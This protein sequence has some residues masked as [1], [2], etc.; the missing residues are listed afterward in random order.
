MW[1]ASQIAETRKTIAH[2][3]VKQILMSA[4]GKEL[5]SGQSARWSAKSGHWI[6]VTAISDCSV[7]SSS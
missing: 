6:V 4:M 3:V 5:T 2:L 1:R 7:K